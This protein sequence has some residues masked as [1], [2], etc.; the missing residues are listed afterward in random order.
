MFGCSDDDSGADDSGPFAGGFLGLGNVERN[1]TRCGECHPAQ[2]ANWAETDHAHAF[3]TLADIGRESTDLI[4][5]RCHNV[6]D[7]GND[8]MDDSLGYVMD[9]NP[10]LRNVQC[11]NCHG[12]GAEHLADPTNAPFPPIGVDL[13]L[14]CGECHQDAHH[15]FVEEWIDSAH[16]E[17]HVSGSSFGLNVAQDPRCAYCHVAQSFIEFVKSDGTNT[18]IT[19]EPEPITCV[20]CHDPHGNGSEGQLRQI[21]GEPINC[22]FCH[23]SGDATIGDEPHH[24]QANV[25]LGEAGYFFDGVENPG[26]ST[27]GSLINNPDLCA[28]CHVVTVPYMREGD[29][30]IPA[31]VGHTFLA[32]PVIDE[33]TGERNVEDCMVCH[34]NPTL[35]LERYE[36]RIEPLFEELEAALEAVP[37]S[38][39]QTEAYLGALFNF[40]LLEADSSRGI[41]NPPLST[42]LLESSIAALE[43]L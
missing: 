28:G 4:C 26:A 21:A 12:P 34:S 20:A 39:R 2:Q 30:E 8:L 6:S 42:V 25:I 24:P 33:T 11:E 3:Q 29:L 32:I 9:A 41:H 40:E 38:Q 1:V 15:P 13:D 5:A 22:A 7:L 43:D 31:Q 14:G 35:L 19:T 10:R 36:Q 16:A 27:H 37:E 17:S 23:N 18:V